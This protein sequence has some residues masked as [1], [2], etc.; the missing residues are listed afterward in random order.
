MGQQLLGV[1]L[2]MTIP[3]QHAMR[4]FLQN[5]VHTPMSFLTYIARGIFVFGR[6]GPASAAPYSMRLGLGTRNLESQDHRRD[7]GG[8]RLQ[9]KYEGLR[10]D[11]RYWSWT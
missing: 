1:E 9:C 5:I 6:I 11:T 3:S 7:P 4:Y 2:P 8:P 10:R